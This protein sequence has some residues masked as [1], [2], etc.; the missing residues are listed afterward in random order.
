MSSPSL[1]SATPIRWRDHRLVLAGEV[2]GG[3]G[4]GSLAPNARERGQ[5]LIERPPVTPPGE[6]VR[7][8]A[9]QEAPI[10]AA[11]GERGGEGGDLAARWRWPPAVSR[12]NET[13]VNDRPAGAE[14]STQSACFCLV[15]PP[16]M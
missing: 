14:S 9:G 15:F 3:A 10:E 16:T 6:R 4:S 1:P 8:A 5:Q 11:L 7:V 2:V 12:W 13:T